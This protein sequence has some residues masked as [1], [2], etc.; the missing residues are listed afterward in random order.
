[1]ATHWKHITAL[2]FIITVITFCGSEDT[3]ISGQWWDWRI[4]IGSADLDWIRGYCAT[5]VL[6]DFG[7]RYASRVV[8][9]GSRFRSASLAVPGQDASGPRDGGIH[10]RWICI[11]S[12]AQ[13]WIWGLRNASLLGFV[14]W[15]RTLMCSVFTNDWIFDCLLTSM[16]TVQAEDGW[17]SFMLVGDLNAIIRSLVSTTT[18]RHGV[19]AFDLTTVSGYCKYNCCQPDPCTLWNTWPPDDWCSRTSTGCCCSKHS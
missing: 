13:I 4:L 19:A 8:V 16:A 2:E 18:K 3:G 9:A 14:V 5:V 7:L 1:M 10:T 12:P 17:A 15:D 11:I 6:I